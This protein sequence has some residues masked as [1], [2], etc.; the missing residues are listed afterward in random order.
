MRTLAELASEALQVQNACNL[1]GI[2]NSWLASVR[3]LRALCPS[4]G[5]DQINRHPINR[6]WAS[7]V[8]DLAGMGLSDID[9][10]G[11]ASDWCENESEAR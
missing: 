2:L 10:Y 1:S 8:H 9:R 7:K 3:R 4:L 11:E 6:L 5:T